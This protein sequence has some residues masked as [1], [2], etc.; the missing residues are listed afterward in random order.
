MAF[1]VGFTLNARLTA[2]LFA[3]VIPSMGLVVYIGTGF[4]SI[5]SK[6]AAEY[7]STA[8]SIAEGAIS[9]VQVVQ[10]FDAFEPLTRDHR[11]S[12]QNA[13][14]FGIRKSFAAAVILGSIYFIA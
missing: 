9:A 14:K 2:I 7:T 10:A 4:L 12:L 11:Q 6:E 5:C 8:A 1:I 3:A 13:S